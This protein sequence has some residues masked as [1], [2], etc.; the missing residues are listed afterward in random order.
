MSLSDPSDRRSILAAVILIVSGG[1]MVLSC[2]GATA[3]VGVPLL[4]IGIFSLTEEAKPGHGAC[5]A[6]AS[7]TKFRRCRE[8]K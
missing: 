2:Q 5:R 8:G 4:S 1:I 7:A 3:I 6:R